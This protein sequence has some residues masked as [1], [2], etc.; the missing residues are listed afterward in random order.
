MTN[1]LELFAGASTNI[2]SIEFNAN[3]VNPNQKQD[4]FLGLVGEFDGAI[5][6]LQWKD[7]NGDWNDTDADVDLWTEGK[8]QPLY[9]NSFLTYSLLI[10][11]AGEST[12]ISA[13]AFGSRA[14]LEE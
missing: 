7:P 8:L 11:G 1:K 10:S 2:R 13:W 5:V 3:D 14:P 4:P 6:K 12:S 9:L